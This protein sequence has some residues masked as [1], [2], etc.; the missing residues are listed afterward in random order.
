M[1]MIMILR[2]L[3]RNEANEL[4]SKFGSDV[5][6]AGEINSKEDFDIYYEVSANITK[7]TKMT[8]KTML[9][10]IMMVMI[11]KAG[12]MILTSNPWIIFLL[13]D[14]VTSQW[15]MSASFVGYGDDGD[16]CG[17]DDENDKFKMFNLVSTRD[18]WKTTGSSLLAGSVTTTGLRLGC[19]M[20]L[21][22]SSFSFSF[23]LPFFL[24]I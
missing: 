13:E 21:T 1:I 5:F 7:F 23:F 6:M 19:P 18:W 4:C 10:T 3:Y 15:Y 2:K 11:A 22:R 24:I 20:L 16:N 12:D 8:T 17:G 14:L 9:V